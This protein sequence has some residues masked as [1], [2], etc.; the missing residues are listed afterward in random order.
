MLIFRANICFVFIGRELMR[1][2][3]FLFILSL[4]ATQV[5]AAPDGRGL[6]LQYCAACHQMDGSGGIGLPLVASKLKDVPDSYLFNT[7]REG[8]VGRIMPAFQALSDAQ[9]NAIVKY[10]RKRTNTTE[11][12]FDL[13]PV[14][15]DL[16]RGAKLFEEHCVRCH[17]VDGS[18]EGDGTGVTMSR[19]RAFMVMPAAISNKG[20][21]ASA[22]DSM[23]H[24][25]IKVGRPDSGMP[26]F[27]KK[28]LSDQDIDDIIV[29]MRGMKGTGGENMAMDSEERPSYVIESPY[30]FETTV[31]N[32]KAALGGS[33]FRIFP[34]R[35]LEQGLI[36]EFSFNKRQL[37]IRFCNFD[38]MYGMLKVEPRLGVVLP[39]RVTVMEQEDG[40][41]VMVVP[42]LK[43]VS[44]W[45]SNDELIELWDE[46]DETFAEILDEATL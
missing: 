24:Q 45:F 6:Y 25:I 43:V 22:P 18:G 10:L 20:F 46:M 14:T 41:V 36:D 39:C 44:R 16:D 15:G 2:L 35:Y 17:G 40:S 38:L 34:E 37:G 32:V 7:I 9:V 26:N 12:V 19:E 42:N 8:R 11:K 33:N 29:H 27:A 28:G 4:F 13:T 23:I 21:M 30:D 31:N 3:L 1:N 5:S